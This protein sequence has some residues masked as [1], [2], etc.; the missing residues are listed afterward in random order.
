[1]CKITIKKQKCL[2]C[3]HK[4]YPKPGK[5]GKVKKPKVCPKCKSVY[6]DTPKTQF[7]N[8]ELE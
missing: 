3:D 8:G 4:W 1:M 2:R 5:D 6:W 7:K